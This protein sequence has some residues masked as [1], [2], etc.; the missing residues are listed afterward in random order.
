MTTTT[1]DTII[2]ECCLDE[3]R[4]GKLMDTLTAARSRDPSVRKADVRDWLR[5]HGE[6]LLG[7]GLVGGA[8]DVRKPETIKADAYE[9]SKADGNT[10]ARYVHNRAND[11]LGEHLHRQGL[12]KRE[13]KV[14]A[15][16]AIRLDDVREWLKKRAD[17]PTPTP[18]AAARSS[19]SSSS[20][21]PAEPKAEEPEPKAEPPE[22]TE[23][24][25]P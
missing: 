11:L 7:C 1:K 13:S 12:N 14:S 24:T 22:S 3:G 10:T 5:K 17:E 8:Y 4:P 19:S 16:E 25:R 18:N 15:A 23:P 2:A 21:K 20:S 9:K 6:R